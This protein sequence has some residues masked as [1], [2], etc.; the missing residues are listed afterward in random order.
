MVDKWLAQ[1]FCAGNDGWTSALEAGSQ[2]F[3]HFPV[4]DGVKQ[5]LR[6]VG[7]GISVISIEVHRTVTGIEHNSLRPAFPRALLQFLKEAAAD[8]LPLQLW[9]HGHV[10]NLRRVGVDEMKPADPH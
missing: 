10:T 8:S 4:R 2:Q 3:F 9:F 5:D 1:S 7:Y 6:A